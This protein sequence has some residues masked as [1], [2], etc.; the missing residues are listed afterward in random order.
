MPPLA[1][2]ILA[3]VLSVLALTTAATGTELSWRPGPSTRVALAGTVLENDLVYVKGSD[4]PAADFYCQA[5]VVQWG[6]ISS[7]HP[8]RYRVRMSAGSRRNFGTSPLVLQAWV[9]Q[10]SGGD[11]EATA[12]GVAPT[13]PWQRCAVGGHAFT[14]P[15]AVAGFRPGNSTWNAASR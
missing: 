12:R 3:G 13:S 11:F 4:E 5:A 14:A 1:A 10:D 9:P 15:R 7:D 6:P 8:G 2:C